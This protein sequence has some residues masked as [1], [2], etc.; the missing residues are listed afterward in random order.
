M[1]HHWAELRLTRPYR[2]SHV[3]KSC[4]S[5]HH[6]QSNIQGQTVKKFVCFLDT[7]SIHVNKVHWQTKYS[8]HYTLYSNPASAKKMATERWSLRWRIQDFPEGG[9]LNSQSGCAYL[10]FLLETA[11]KWK[12]LDPRGRGV[13][14]APLEVLD[15]I[16]YLVI[17]IV[18][19]ESDPPWPGWCRSE[20]H[21]RS[22]SWSN[23][24]VKSQVH[25]SGCGPMTPVI[26]RGDLHIVA[27]HMIGFGIFSVQS[28]L[29]LQKNIWKCLINIYGAS[30]F[31][32]ICNALIQLNLVL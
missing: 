6:H 1:T 17:S 22:W 14:G 4:T 31:L 21:S 18:A 20:L 24:V 9:G 25:E 16:R 5:Y 29:Y 26:S 32:I 13:P 19:N 30:I 3:P 28:E 23:V 11:C 12:N 15:R 7:N 8:C 2:V 10:L 27:G